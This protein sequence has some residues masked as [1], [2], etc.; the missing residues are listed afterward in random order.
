VIVKKKR[1]GSAVIIEG[2]DP[3]DG[4]PGDQCF[5]CEYY[6]KEVTCP[7]LEA[8]ATNAVTLNPE[9]LMVR[10]CGFYKEFKRALGVI[11]G[12]KK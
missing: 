10:N 4:D 2:P 3:T 8:L 12:G 9:G 6:C 11:K 5:S 1:R 7:L